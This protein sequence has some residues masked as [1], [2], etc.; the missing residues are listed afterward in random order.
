MTKSELIKAMAEKSDGI[1][2]QRACNLALECLGLVVTDVVK[3]EDAVKISNICTIS[4]VRKAAHTGRN[5]MT[6]ESIEIPEKIVAKAKFN[7][8]WKKALND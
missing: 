7:S 1:L 2:T 3:A 4:G 6:G 8:G 5:P